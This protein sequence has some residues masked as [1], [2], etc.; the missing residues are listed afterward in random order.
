MRSNISGCNIVIILRHFQP[1]NSKDGS[2][3]GFKNKAGI[4]KKLRIGNKKYLVDKPLESPEC[5]L[6]D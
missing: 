3:I 6:E 2:F 4:Q 5:R 1:N